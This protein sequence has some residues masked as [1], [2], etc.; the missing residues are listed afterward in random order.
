MDIQQFSGPVHERGDTYLY[1]PAHRLLQ[2]YIA[3]YTL[4]FPVAGAMSVAYTI[5]PTASATLAISVGDSCM[6]G[7]LNGAD[8][9]AVCVG[10]HA[11]LQRMM[12]LV[13]F[14]PGCLRPFLAID[15]QELADA[16]LAL[17]ALDATLQRT[18]MALLED[19]HS[20]PT[21]V[22]SLDRLFLSMLRPDPANDLVAAS[23]RQIIARRGMLTVGALAQS[24]HYSER[25]LRRVFA[26]HVGVAPKQFLRIVRGNHA[27]H[28]LQRQAAGA[29]MA[30]EAGYFDQ[31]HSIH[32]FR[33]LFGITPEEYL[34]NM[35]VYYND[36]YKM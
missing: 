25:Q 16:S 34:R 5:L 26:Q 4:T 12:L 10:G 23:V 14:H 7:G 15:Q 35:S 2:G 8:T 20:V 3:N 21:L 17:D 27:V 1:L 30:T 18:L 29:D 13:E 9:R 6:I 11:A 22:E 36:P 24:M 19:A 28:L 33:A 31:A 32:D